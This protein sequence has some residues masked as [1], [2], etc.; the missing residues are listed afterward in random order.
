MGNQVVLDTN[1]FISALF[2][3]GN[4]N[5][6]LRK[7]YA[8]ELKLLTSEEIL[9]E[10][11][12]ILTRERKFELTKGE[13]T[14]HIDIIKSNSELLMPKIRVNEITEDP[15]DNKF[16]ECAVAGKADYIV[17][18]DR[19]LLNLKKYENIR[20]LNSSEFLK[21]FRRFPP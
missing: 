17:S 7:C 12:R 16:L 19:H 9:G 20:I 21:I 8:K 1:V 11:A 5:E 3:K 4:P 10:I 2:W 15:A 18:G 14:K 13:I 6:I